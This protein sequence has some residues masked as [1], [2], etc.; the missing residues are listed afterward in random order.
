VLPKS[1][2]CNSGL[3]HLYVRR[4][5][6]NQ[7]LGYGLP[8]RAWTFGDP[9]IQT[10]DGFKYSFNGYGEY[11]LLKILNKTTDNE[12]MEVQART[13]PTKDSNGKP[14]NATIFSA[15]AMKDLTTNATAQIELGSDEK[16]L[17]VYHKGID[18]TTAFQSKTDYILPDTE[19]TVKR[20]IDSNNNTQSVS[21]LFKS[22]IDIT[23]S[24]GIRMLSISVSIP[25]SLKN[26]ITTKGLMGVYN[27]DTTDDLTTPDGNILPSNSSEEYIYY[28]FGL[29]WA[30][31][32]SIFKYQK[33]FSAKDFTDTSFKPLFI[34]KTSEQYK[35][36]LTVCSADNN[37]CIYDYIA[38]G[39][40][41]IAKS[42][43]S[44]QQEA[45][46][47][48]EDSKNTAPE[49]SGNR[50]V[51][52]TSNQTVQVHLIVTDAE[53]DT[54]TIIKEEG[55]DYFN[56]SKDGPKVTLS[57]YLTNLNPVNISVSAKDSKNASSAIFFMDIVLCSGCSSHGVCS[58]ENPITS[59]TNFILKQCD[60]EEEYD[61][62]HC[63]NDFDGCA[64]NPCPPE[65]NCTDFSPED[66]K[67]KN[68]SSSCSCPSGYNTSNILRCQDINECET[69]SP[70]EHNCINTIGSYK[71]SC[72]SGYNLINNSKCENTSLCSNKCL[73]ADGCT[74]EEGKAKCFCNNGYV[75]NNESA[76]VDKNECETNI[77]EGQCKNLNG[78]FECSCPAGKQVSEKTKC[79]ACNDGYYGEKCQ[80]NC[81]TCNSSYSSGCDVVT[82]CI[83][84][85]GWEGATCETDINECL[86]VTICNN[87][88]NC[89]NKKGD[90]E[91]QCREGFEKEGENCIDINECQ[92]NS[93]LCQQK[94]VN[95]AG[96]YA[97]QCDSGYKLN[98]SQC[99]DINECDLKTDGCEHNCVNTEG[100]FQ[101]ECSSGYEL[102]ANRKNCSKTKVMDECKQIN[103]SHICD[104][105]D[106]IASC[107][108]PK[109]YELD[110]QTNTTCIETDMC[111]PNPCK[112]GTCQNGT[113]TFVCNCD[114][115][116]E[117][118]NDKITCKECSANTYGYN[119]N[120]TCDCVQGN[121]HHIKGCVCNTNYT[122]DTCNTR[123]FCTEYKP[124]DN[125]T[126]TCVNS[127]HSHTCLCKDG[128][129]KVPGSESC[130]ISEY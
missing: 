102:N 54:I 12:I 108:C 51:V 43:G 100:S 23:I 79:I 115:G 56:M 113:N 20:N 77:C 107:T 130:Q 99:V 76:C 1:Y 75:L 96:N 95:F 68:I 8:N 120:M 103:C 5:P 118:D 67:T 59:M 89:V 50:T 6:I 94:C 46:E 93:S 87:N 36:A 84:N 14:I 49:F 24:V 69:G 123:D 110:P 88:E 35:K 71:C 30:I 109:F 63:Q 62:D 73:K 29:P 19:M 10:L 122:G 4:R 78:S 2:C 91:C 61:G 37:A 124:C 127:Q 65:G 33:G 18:L 92:L 26:D 42:S 80:G 97:C 7:C 128:Y 53:N 104:V 114:V 101:C 28:N 27:D 106:G 98:G 40:E 125:N 74:A 11:V 44:V 45:N 57:I 112:S 66:H 105:N 25:E 111:S 116:Y 117:L 39:D 41:S 126:S 70:C 32:S 47:I 119:C 83:C 3:C 38:T 64:S 82:G 55:G 81:A 9:H 16:T 58:D 34:D 86:N 17:V 21:C 48:F 85:D 13:T 129:S 52:V 90:Y 121:C 60:C 72:R 22:G 15:F 31:N